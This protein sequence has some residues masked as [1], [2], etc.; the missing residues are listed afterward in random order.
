MGGN[1]HV[2]AFEP[3]PNNVV[4]LRENLSRNNFSE[5]DVI[6]AAVWSHLGV[7][8]FQRSGAG[9]PEESTR[10]GSVV[11]SMADRS[12]SSL[13]DAEAITLD[14]FA[15]SH[16][17]PTIIKVDV[18]GAELEVL[19]GAQELLSQA[20]PVWMFE[21]HHQPAATL[22]EENLWQHDYRIEWLAMHPNFPFPR[23]M[24]ARPAK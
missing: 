18:E 8:K 19:Q 23:H 16:P 20:R 14:S 6:S 13:I 4:V 9:H 3:D 17:A 24:L 21:V 7:V 15:Q 5:P 11:A 22:L 2:V 12:D 1:G 10:R